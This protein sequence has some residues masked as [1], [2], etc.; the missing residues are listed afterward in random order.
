MSP[1]TLEV[2][3]VTMRFGGLKALADFSLVLQPGELVGLIG[4][5]G[6]GKTT[7]FNA[8]TGVYQPTEGEVR[9][10]GERVN[11]RRPHQICARGRGPHL[12]EHPA[13]PRADARS[14]TSASPATPAPRA[15]S[16]TPSS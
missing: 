13:L 16:S 15:A 8:I 12:P 3:G 11:G 7:A 9:V 14:T 10:G 6:A 1:A 4:P 2:S 5:N